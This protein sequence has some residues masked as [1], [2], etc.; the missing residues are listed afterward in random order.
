MRMLTILFTIFSMS[1]GLAQ[2]EMHEAQGHD[3][4]EGTGT[5]SEQTM[6]EASSANP[7]EVQSE[8]AQAQEPAPAGSEQSGFSRGSVVRS[9]F[10][11]GIDAREPLDKLDELD[12]RHRSVYYFTELRDMSGQTATHRWE[13]D[14]KV[15]AEV[16]FQVNGPRWRVWSKK[17]LVPG[18]TGQWT[19][20]VL[21][22]A[23]EVISEDVLEYTEAESATEAQAADT[24]ETDMEGTDG[25]DDM[26][27]PESVQMPTPE[28][29]KAEEAGGPSDM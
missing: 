15:M 12:T 29:D 22:G 11:T 25:G 14:G 27:E 16:A 1:V 18:W 23:G 10:T 5:A 19:V 26:S 6:P 21:N 4:G 17:T 28:S 8:P 2:A 20:S 7:G 9:V 13:H 3:T 24:G